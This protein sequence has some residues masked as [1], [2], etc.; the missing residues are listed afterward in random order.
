MFSIYSENLKLQNY[1]LKFIVYILKKKFLDKNGF[2]KFGS[3]NYQ[4]I[5]AKW[6]L[7]ILL[8]SSNLENKEIKFIKKIFK[9][10]SCNSQFLFTKR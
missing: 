7:D 6:I 4:F 10:N 1:S 5:F 8:F 9:K 2:F 3:S